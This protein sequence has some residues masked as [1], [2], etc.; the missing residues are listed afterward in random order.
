MFVVQLNLIPPENTVQI[1]TSHYLSGKS[2]GIAGRSGRREVISN[3]GGES[4][5]VMEYVLKLQNKFSGS[6]LGR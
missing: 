4:Y 2:W 6:I 3:I 5:P 1:D